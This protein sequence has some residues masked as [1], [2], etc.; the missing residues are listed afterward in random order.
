MK[1]QRQI[2]EEKLRVELNI[3]AQYKYKI[4][5]LMHDKFN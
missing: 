1:R 4:E 2:E 5:S 3:K